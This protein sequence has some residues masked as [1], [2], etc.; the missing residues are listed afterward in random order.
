[1]L[2][3]PLSIA[4]MSEAI[5][6][7]SEAVLSARY[8]AVTAFVGDVYSLKAMAELLEVDLPFEGTV[9]VT[10]LGAYSED[11]DLRGPL[12]GVSSLELAEP[13]SL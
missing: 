13:S 5:L 4:F 1:V 12:E 6:K 7:P 8:L 9:G 10:N 11:C 3:P 2:R